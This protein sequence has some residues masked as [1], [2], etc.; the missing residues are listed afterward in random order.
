MSTRA[1][2]ATILMLA[3]AAGTFAPPAVQASL[4]ID[5]TVTGRVTDLR[6]GDT[7]FL[8]GHPYKVLPNSLAARNFSSLRM[9][10]VVEL[11]LNGPPGK[12]T[13]RVTAIS[14]REQAQ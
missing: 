7:I 4:K 11:V 3:L 13:S 9:G 5:T 12:D 8:D 10:Q 14:T 2:W 1:R 6:G